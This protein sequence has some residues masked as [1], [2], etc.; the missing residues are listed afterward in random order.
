[1]ENYHSEREHVGDFVDRWNEA[2]SRT[3]GLTIALGALLLLAG[4]ASALSPLSLYAVI[5]AAVSDGLIVGGI[6]GVAAWSRTPE[7]F[8]S[9]VT[10]VMGILNALLGF[11]LLTL[12][13]Y[14]TAGTLTFLLAVLFVAA[15]AERL[16]TAYRMHRFG[17]EGWAVSLVTG[18]VNALAG[19]TFLL[20]PLFSSLMLGYLMA[21]YLIVGGASLLVE[22]AAMHRL[23]A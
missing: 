6:G 15:G 12:P 4:I 13:S 10:L 17:V 8:R 18:I 3:R 19:V 2:V 5:Q 11:M 23:E 1:M 20:L 9:P 22:G 14:L 16:A 7:V 21:G